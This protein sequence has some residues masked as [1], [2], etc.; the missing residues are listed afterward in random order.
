[1]SLKYHGLIRKRSSRQTGIIYQAL[2]YYYFEKN[3][4]LLIEASFWIERFVNHRRMILLSVL[5]DAKMSLCATNIWSTSKRRFVK[6]KLFL[7]Y[8]TIT[9]TVEMSFIQLIW[10]N[11]EK[12]KQI[13]QNL[14]TFEFVWILLNTFEYIWIHLNTFEYIWMHL[15]AFECIWIP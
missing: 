14:N 5:V 11:F 3:N 1:M 10:S 4:V 7:K 6:C 9:R 15:N 12:F 2:R 8:K 13:W